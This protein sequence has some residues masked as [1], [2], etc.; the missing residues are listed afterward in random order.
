MRDQTVLRTS[1]RANRLAP[2]APM[3]RSLDYVE[4]YAAWIKAQKE[5]ER[6]MW[7][8][9]AYCAAYNLRQTMEKQ[10]EICGC[11]NHGDADNCRYPGCVRHP[12]HGDLLW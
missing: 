6:L 11:I 3:E 8:A 5:R 10:A 7:E 12:S 9:E 4:P 2:F 1:I